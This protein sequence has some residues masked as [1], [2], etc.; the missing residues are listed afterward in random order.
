[1][2]VPKG[3]WHTA[4][5]NGPWRMLFITAG[6]GAQHREANEIA[7]PKARSMGIGGAAAS[8]GSRSSSLSVPSLLYRGRTGR[9]TDLQGGAPLTI[10]ATA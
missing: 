7:I 3:I 4:C 9:F 6:E 2:I 5:V 8:G 10:L 1:M